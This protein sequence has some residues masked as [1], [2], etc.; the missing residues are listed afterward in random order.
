[1]NA[2]SERERQPDE[3]LEVP[4]RPKPQVREYPNGIA[5]FPIS[6]MHEYRLAG[7]AKEGENI[8]YTLMFEMG[9]PG[10]F[11]YELGEFDRNI[12][13][14]F[15]GVYYVDREGGPKGEDAHYKIEDPPE[16]LRTAILRRFFTGEALICG[17]VFMD[18]EGRLW[19]TVSAENNI[20]AC[21]VLHLQPKGI[22]CEFNVVD[23][24]TL[25]RLSCCRVTFNG[26]SF[27]YEPVDLSASPKS[28][29]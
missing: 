27:Y 21:L 17:V 9:E 15:A 28:P 23:A 20:E 10:V 12:V 2:H 7:G 4:G 13:V 29:C 22:G 11:N 5:E 3:I 25:A 1:M 8:S 18:D 24:N 14:M 16:F 26:E 6:E 19:L